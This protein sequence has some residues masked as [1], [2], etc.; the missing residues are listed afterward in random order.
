MDFAFTQEQEM[1]RQ[2]V[3]E[4]MEREATEEYLRRLDEEGLYPYE[5][6]DKWVEM[7]LF[8]LPFPEE[9]G[10]T[11]GGVMDF[12]V[13]SEELGR[14]GYDISAAYGINVF[15]GLNLLRHGTEEQKRTYIPRIIRGETR[16][17]ISMT[18]PQAGS[19]V[20][21]MRTTARLEGDEFVINGQKVFATAAGVRNN[22][23][24]LY[25][26][27]DPAV[28]YRE[29]TSAILV[30]N[31][32]PGLEIRRLRTLGRRMLGT[33][34]LFFNDVR[35]PRDHLV[36]PL[37]GGWRI[38]LSGLELERVMTS[39]AYIGNAQTVVDEALA[40][41]QQ[42]EQFGRRIGDFQAIAHMLADMQTAVDAARLL[43]YRAA[44][45]V[46]EG[47]PALKEVS[48]AKLFGSETFAQVANQGM[49]ILG[50]Y[51]YIMETPM[52]R[53]FRD[54]RIT[55]VTAGTSQ[56]QRNIIA[57]QLGLRPR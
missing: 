2:A 37:H 53:H 30:E 21:G 48:M 23:I 29:G 25:C 32:R 4:L 35:V 52:Q 44:W 34:E 38:L 16:F 41:A 19:D 11:G 36:G 54:A 8:A 56:V 14:K 55:T 6:Y 26:R 57:R 9:Y 40:Y 50:G 45:L 39:A 10:G 27:T 22:I 33:N 43:T 5:L 17:S 49:Q 12:V 46:A 20:G 42:R 47:K 13:V 31:D 3:R 1:L 15:L 28:H 18:E 24:V 51:G 7:G